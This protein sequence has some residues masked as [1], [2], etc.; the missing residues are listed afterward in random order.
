MKIFSN[1][2]EISEVFPTPILT[3]GN[4]DGVH[5]GHQS[6]FRL[7]QERAKRLSGTSLVLTFDPHPQKILSPDKE[8]YLIEKVLNQ[9]GAFR[10]PSETLQNWIRR[11]QKNQPVS[12]QLHDLKS[13][14]ELHYRYRFDSNG[15][16]ATERARL[17]SDSQSWIDRYIKLNNR[18]NKS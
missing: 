14:L 15:I 2:D 3:M 17:K 4:F 8:F 7:V 12:P 6:I 11:L 10:H 1:L 16:K 5:F 18:V 13:M 9:S